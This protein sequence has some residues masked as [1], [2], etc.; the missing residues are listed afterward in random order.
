MDAIEHKPQKITRWECEECGQSGKHSAECGMTGVLVV[1]GQGHMVEWVRASALEGAVDALRDI[2]AS[3]ERH[4]E[5]RMAMSERKVLDMA[6]R[7]LAAG[8]SE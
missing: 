5:G 2:E 8:G 7:G 4:L 1:S 3:A 6:R